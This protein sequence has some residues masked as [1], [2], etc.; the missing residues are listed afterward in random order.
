MWTHKPQVSEF[1]TLNETPVPNV[2]YASLVQPPAC[3]QRPR[4]ADLTHRFDLSGCSTFRFTSRLYS[5]TYRKLG[6][7]A[8]VKEGI[9]GGE[10]VD[11]AKRH[12]SLY[13]DDETVV[14]LVENTLFKVHRYFFKRHSKMF[15]TMFSLPPEVGKPV[16]GQSDENPICVPEVLSKDFERLLSLFY[17]E[18]AGTGDLIT[19]EEWTSILALA[20][21]WEFLGYRDLAIERL[22]QLASPVDRILLARMYDVTPWLTPAYLELCKR[23]EALTFEEGVRLG[24]KDVVLLSEIRQGIRG[25]NRVTMHDRNINVLIDR[26]LI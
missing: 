26:K 1:R 25:T 21:K 23:D 17:P 6:M 19:V 10:Q 16:E 3:D 7:L 22:S 12:Q 4:T 2:L 24:M 9:N 18:K 20:T 15:A 11:N 13:F 14:F 8:D 5:A